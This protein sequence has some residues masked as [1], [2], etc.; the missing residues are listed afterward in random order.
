MVFRWDIL[1]RWNDLQV[2]KW[3]WYVLMRYKICVIVIELKF[4]GCA[5]M[6]WIFSW[7]H[8]ISNVFFFISTYIIALCCACVF[9]SCRQEFQP[10]SH[11]LIR[12]LLKSNIFNDNLHAYINIYHTLVSIILWYSIEHGPDSRIFNV[13]RQKFEGERNWTTQRNMDEIINWSVT[14]VTFSPVS[15]FLNDLLYEIPSK[16]HI[17]SPVFESQ[18]QPE[19]YT[20]LEVDIRGFIT[21]GWDL[22]LLAN[23]F[24]SPM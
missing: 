3:K 12:K 24:R 8:S 2:D 5:C 16:V 21:F 10:L 18:L 4:C 23:Q 15:Y 13:Q 14:F 19:R 20:N 17:S 22:A 6:K 9:W 11:Y 1:C 7:H